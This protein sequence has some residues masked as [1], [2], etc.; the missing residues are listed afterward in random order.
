MHPVIRL[1]ARK[2]RQIRDRLRAA[3]D[4]SYSKRLVA[5]LELD[6]GTPVADVADLLGVSRQSVYNWADGYRASA[7]PD[8]L[9]DRYGVGRPS[10]WTAELRGLL[11]AALPHRPERLGYAGVN[12]TVPLLREYLGDS[13]GLRLSDDTI[14]RHLDRLGYV[15]KRSRYVLP[16]DP[17]REKKTGHPP[18]AGGVAAAGRRAGG[19]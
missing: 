8:T 15:W 7:D 10:S 5:L 3:R 6:R 4:A 18:A 11:R 1:T 12:W 19:G 2:R 16:P 17:E 13:G 9:R 14:R